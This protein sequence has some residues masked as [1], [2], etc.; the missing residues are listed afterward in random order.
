MYIQT[1]TRCN[2]DCEHCCFSATRKGEDMSREVFVGAIQL[3]CARGDFITIG[4]GEPTL[5]K[6]FL[7]MVNFAREQHRRGNL[8]GPPLIITNGKLYGKTHKLL[9][10]WE[11]Y[12][13]F[14]VELSQD[15]YH[16][17]ITPLVVRRFRELKGHYSGGSVGIRTV[18]TL[19]PWGRAAD[20]A[21]GLPVDWERDPCVCDD[22]TIGPD[23]TIWSCGC[24]TLAIGNVLDDKLDINWWN[25]EFCHTGGRDPDGL[26]EAA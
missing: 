24:K 10:L 5:N 7:D 22:L 18:K 21:R 4:G 16:E 8:E 19:G 1:T 2:M 6:H 15:D 26:R 12:Q 20:L 13:D 3:A 14:D 23:G 11:K 9:D 25:Q 17:P